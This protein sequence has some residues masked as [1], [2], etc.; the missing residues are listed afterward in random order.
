MNQ[1]EPLPAKF[2]EYLFMELHGRFGNAFFDKF[3]TGSLNQNGDDV[4]VENAKQVW[5]KRLSG[6]SKERLRNALDSNYEYP[7]SCDDFMMNCVVLK[8]EPEYKALP[9]KFTEEEIEKNKGRMNKILTDIA[10]KNW[11]AKWR[12]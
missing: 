8:I 12:S 7:P 2:I 3:R 9:R 10:A 5:A 6:M 11:R 4:G 1:S